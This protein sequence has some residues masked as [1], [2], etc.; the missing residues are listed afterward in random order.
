LT[1]E[2]SLG[3]GYHAVI[4]PDDITAMLK[5]WSEWMQGEKEVFSMEMR[6]RRHDGVY[7]WMLAKCC[8]L[9][10]EDGKPIKW[11]G[12]TTDIHD[13]VMSRIAAATQKQEMLKVLAHGDVNVYSI[14]DKKMVE[15]AEGGVP[16][17]T[18][19]DTVSEDDHDHHHSLLGKD[20]IE[21][22]QARQPGGVPGK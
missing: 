6:Y 11:Y 20:A 1:K 14:D 10:D 13:I 3:F 18:S 22:A 21:A 16:C 4:H 8:T 9:N 7:R 19:F 15:W 12:S 17:M 2:E 5:G